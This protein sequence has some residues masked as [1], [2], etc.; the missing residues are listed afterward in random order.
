MSR[1]AVVVAAWALATLA[2]AV[3]GWLLLA[4]SE[5]GADRI[6]GVLLLLAAV[7][8]AAAT[9]VQARGAGPAWVPAAASAGLVLGGLVAGAV[10]LS[11]ENVFA[12]DVL[13]AGGVPVVAG[14]VTGALVL[15]ARRA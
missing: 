7:A 8:A 3:V 11:A 2:V 5:R 1:R 12:A 6:A 9:A 4:L 15:R 10:M 14:V 13:L